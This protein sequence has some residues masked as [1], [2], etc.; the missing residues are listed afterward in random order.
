[1]VR[2]RAGARASLAQREIFNQK[3]EET[4]IE[5]ERAIKHTHTERERDTQ[6]TNTFGGLFFSFL[7]DKVITLCVYSVQN[8]RHISRWL[9]RHAC[10]SLLFVFFFCLSLFSLLL[11]L[12]IFFFV[13]FFYTLDYVGCVVSV[14]LLAGTQ[15][16][17]ERKRRRSFP[18]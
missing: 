17:R 1:M 5:K 15:R 16:E 8:I 14:C 9:S 12:F 3:R 13:F 4:F 11:F 2:S 10:D 6:K 18:P 7:P